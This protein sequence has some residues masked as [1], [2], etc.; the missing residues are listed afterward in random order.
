MNRTILTEPIERPISKL[1]GYNI[2][3]GE[4]IL[5]TSV[6][7]RVELNYLTGKTYSSEIKDFTLEGDEYLAWGSDD[8]YITELVKSKIITL[9]QGESPLPSL[10]VSANVSD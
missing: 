7:L 10:D 3:V 4:L 8:N 5:G 6:R 2:M 1:I 9:F